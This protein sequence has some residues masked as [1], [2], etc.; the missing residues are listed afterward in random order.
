MFVFLERIY[1]IIINGKYYFKVVEENY[2]KIENIYIVL[3]NNLNYYV[4]SK[5]ILK[6]LNFE[7]CSGSIN[8][9]S[10]ESGFGKIILFNILI[11]LIISYLG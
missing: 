6:N 10:G 1:N 9:V 11:K 4:D 7:F 2:I 8:L 3:I 5:Y